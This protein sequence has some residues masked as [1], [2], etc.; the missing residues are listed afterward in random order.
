MP[1]RVEQHVAEGRSP[2][3]APHCQ[4]QRLRQALRRVARLRR[5]PGHHPAVREM[6]EPPLRQQR[7]LAEARRR[8]DQ[9]GRDIA[10]HRIG[11][12]QPRP[13]HQVARHPRRR[14]PQQQVVA[15]AVG[16]GR[17]IGAG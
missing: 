5:Y 15:A 16:I 9:D 14:N 1:G 7:G 4:R 2:R 17:P 11:R 6:L 3:R 12:Q 13:R 10:E 8:L